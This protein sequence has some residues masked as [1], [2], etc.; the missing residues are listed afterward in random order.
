MWSDLLGQSGTCF[1]VEGYCCFSEENEN[2]LQ[3]KGTIVRLD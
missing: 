2:V 3:G 1:C